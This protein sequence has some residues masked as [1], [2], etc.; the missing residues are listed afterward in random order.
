V[1][2]TLADTGTEGKILILGIP[3]AAWEYMKDGKTHDFDLTAIGFP[4]KLMLFGGDTHDSIMKT[5]EAAARAQGTVIEDMRN[6]DFAIKSLH[7]GDDK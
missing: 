7:E 6:K 2:F 3:R 4:V 5:L 1:L